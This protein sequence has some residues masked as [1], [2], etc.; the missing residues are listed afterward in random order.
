MCTCTSYMY[1]TY[2]R[3]LQSPNWILTLAMCNILSTEVSPSEEGFCCVACGIACDGGGR[4]CG[5]AML[6]VV[7]GEEVGGA[8]GCGLT[9]CSRKGAW[10]REVEGC[11]GVVLD[12]EG[13]CSVTRLNLSLSAADIRLNTEPVYWRTCTFSVNWSGHLKCT[14]V[15]K[16]EHLTNQDTSLLRTPHKSGHLT[17]QDT[18][19]IRTPH[20]SGHLTNQDTSLVRTPHWS[21]HV[22]HLYPEIRTCALIRTS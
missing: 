10:E 4:R 19:L 11:G 12:V 17:D 21:G 14:S 5:C 20:Y 2:I 7:T 22:R 3:I 13:T 6:A 9:C 8:S 15:L 1:Y 18:S 16:S